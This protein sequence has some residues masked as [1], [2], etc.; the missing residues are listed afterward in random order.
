MIC[1]FIGRGFDSN[2]YLVKGKVSTLIDSGTGIYFEDTIESLKE[3]IDIDQIKQ[4]ILTHEHV[5][6]TGGA[7]Y[8]KREIKDLRILAHKKTADTIERGI[9]PTSILFSLPSPKIK[10]DRRLE[11]GDEIMIG[12]DVYQVLHT[13]GHSEGSICLY[14][15]NKG[16]L[17][18]GDTIFSYGGIGRYDLPG[19]DL[20]KLER[21]IERLSELRIRDI[22]PGHGD[23]I[24]GAGEK[25]VNLS[26]R[27]VKML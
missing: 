13:P 18:S 27:N 26:L 2:I 3:N 8:F 5:D 14:Q 11:E 16:I 15:K 22:Y 1:T 12:D 25:H 20:Y 6:H 21:S 24:T 17:F 10:I 23:Y 4:L 9:E 19:G 7:E